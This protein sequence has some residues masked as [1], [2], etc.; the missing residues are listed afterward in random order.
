MAVNVTAWP[1]ADGLML[2]NNKPGYDFEMKYFNADGGESK[3]GELDGGD[4]RETSGD[5]AQTSSQRRRCAS[6]EKYS[7]GMLPG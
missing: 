5:Q 6:S 4:L 1:G 2:L 3:R 7:Y